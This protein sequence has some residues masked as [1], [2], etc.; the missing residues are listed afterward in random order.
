MSDENKVTNNPKG[1]PKTEHSW[2]GEH[3]HNR[4]LPQA[5]TKPNI[6]DTEVRTLYVLPRGQ[7]TV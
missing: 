3:M 1:L 2:L 7:T 6:T 5:E 4:Q